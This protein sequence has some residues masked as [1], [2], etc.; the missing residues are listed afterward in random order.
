MSPLSV[1]TFN[2]HAGVDGWGRPY[3][4]LE[5]CRSLDA[6]VLVLQEVW[7]PDDEEGLA[8][9]IAAGLGYRA[10][11]VPAAM[12]RLYPPVT[13]A[14]S[15]WGP[16][17]RTRLGVGVR[18]E[19]RRR[20]RAGVR[21]GG[22]GAPALRRR[23]G[24]RGTIGLALL[25]RV[26]TGPVEVLDLGSLPGDGVRR[27]ALRTVVEGPDAPLSVAGTHMSHLRHGS[28][29]QIRRLARL[30][31]GREQRGLLLGDMNLWG[32]PLSLLLP[33]WR[34]AVV[35]RTWPSW[36]R[37]FQIDHVLATDSVAVLDGA[38]V[39]AGRSDHLPL[40]VVVD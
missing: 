18:V 30:L 37:L 14:P 2:L 40:R 28:P 19:A 29:V 7:V 27:I 12:V 24:Q 13:A 16:L 22:T 9:R 15:S 39:W 33:G 35:G 5:A 23:V 10:T 36:R 34:R 17:D 25:A 1:A 38:V 31:P 3:D 32:P 20:R 11:Y 26:P 6:D 8:Q 21:E 4:V